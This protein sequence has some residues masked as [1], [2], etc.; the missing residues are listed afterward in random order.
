[1][2]YLMNRNGPKLQKGCHGSRFNDGTSDF[3][4]ISV[5]ENGVRIISQEEAVSALP[6]YPGLGADAAH[7]GQSTPTDRID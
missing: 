7:A 6:H 3:R 4:K 1:M 2:G 5:A